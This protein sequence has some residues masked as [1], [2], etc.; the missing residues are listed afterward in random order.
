MFGATRDA[1]RSDMLLLHL[2][3]QITL[4]G[5]NWLSMY[6]NEVA[7]SHEVSLDR[8]FRQLRFNWDRFDSDSSQI[9]L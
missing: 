4:L 7:L 2:P 5:E 9:L 6:A 1:I 8:G 3:L